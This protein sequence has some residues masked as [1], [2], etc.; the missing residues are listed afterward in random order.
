VATTSVTITN[1]PTATLST[2]QVDET[3]SA[4]NGSIDLTITGGVGPFTF[5]WDNGATT[6]DISGLAANTYN[7]TVTDQNACVATT[8][9]TITNA[10]TATLSTTQVDETCSASNGSIDLTVTGGVGPFTFAWDNGA[11]TEDISG[12][13]PNT[14]NVSVTDFNGCVATTS[15][16]ILSIGGPT[17]VTLST[18]FEICTAANGSVK[19]NSVIGGTAAFQYSL[20][21]ITYSLNDSISGLSA[22]NYTLYVQDANLCVFTQA[23]SITD[24]AGPSAAT[25]NTY[26]ETCGSSNGAFQVT[27]V[28]GNSSPFLFS[29]D[30]ITYSALDTLSGLSAQ[31][32]NLFIQDTNNCVFAQPFT[33]NNIAGPTGTVSVVYDETC[34]GANGVL[35]INGITGGTTPYLYSLDGVTYSA[36]D[37]LTNFAAGNYTLYV[38][39]VNNCLFTEPF[40]IA[41]LAGP[42]GTA[43]T[44]QTASC[45]LNV[46]VIDITSV[47]GGN[48]PFTYSTDGITY[49]ANDSIINLAG[50]SYN[51]FV[52]DSNNCIYTEPFTI[53][54]TAAVVALASN[55]T[56]LCFGETAT[57]TASGGTI[58]SW[59]NGAGNTATVNVS[60]AV[61]TLYTVTVT[62]ANNCSATEQVQVNINALPA[63][64]L[65]SA[66][67]SLTFCQGNSVTLTSSY[68]GG[69]TWTGGT[70]LDSLVASTSGDVILTYT[71]AN[72]CSSEDTVTVLVNPLPIVN[73]SGPAAVCEGSAPIALSGG[74]PISGTYSGN[75][76]NAGNFDPNVT[77]T[78]SFDFVYS[79]TD[80]NGC[81]NA[82]TAQMVVNGKPSL[83]LSSDSLFFCLGNDVSILQVASP[84]GGIYTGTGINNNE[85]NPAT[86]GEGIFTL[87]YEYNDANGCS[88]NIN[89]TAQVGVLEVEIPDNLT[90]I[91]GE[92]IAI[93]VSTN[94]YRSNGNFTYSWE[95]SILFNDPTAE[96]P[97]L[98]TETD[99]TISVTV[100]DGYCVAKDAARVL[101]VE[102]DVVVIISTSN[103]GSG[104]YDLIIDNGNNVRDL[105]AEVFNTN[106]AKLFELVYK[107]NPGK[108]KVPIDITTLSDGAYFLR[109]Q[110]G[111]TVKTLKLAKVQRK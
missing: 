15:A 98:T 85:F 32:Y 25:L 111:N 104:E 109:V 75:G 58:Y 90:G 71:D 68:I 39:D 44:L 20:D 60:P 91:Q 73:L 17:A 5:A 40:V 4:S 59:D 57:L 38:T 101:V 13:V 10:P 88:N 61:S 1:A 56:T 100:S 76:V 107:V 2:T 94:Y 96:N 108:N 65:I 18:Y 28:T 49:A 23:F 92:Q 66:N 93:T 70:T 52:S 21:G 9:V 53:N 79:F 36:N 78:G 72:G 51:I 33:I 106:G 37:S 46:G 95:P 29:T 89:L 43:Y 97:I 8:S 27:S 30:G 12:L 103:P 87:T 41:N 54:A 110:I 31:N 102:P 24:L 62:D 19:V 105:I 16:T 11:T 80:G 14:Y 63:A 81:T 69:N 74:T 42:T 50:G 77:G 26:D 55:D 84:T 83:S 99:T 47:T 34:T 67:G 22:N 7:V 6:E 86:A 48:A 82:D 64:P 3:C 35:D 45:G